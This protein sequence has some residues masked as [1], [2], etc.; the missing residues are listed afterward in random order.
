MRATVSQGDL[1]ETVMQKTLVEWDRGWLVGSFDYASL[2][3][4]VLISRRFG[5][6]QSPKV[7]L[8]DDFS[9]S[10]VNHAVQSYEAPQPQST[11]VIA[12]VAHA[13]LQNSNARD[14]TGK[15]FDLSSLPSGG[16]RARE[17]LGRLCFML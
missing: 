3:A 2:P 8:I 13:L 5:I 14:L 4:D 10:G 16:D 17:R 9:Q 1:D 6:T 15:A 7:R 11:D 12:S